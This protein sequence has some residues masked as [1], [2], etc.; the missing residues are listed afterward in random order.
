LI[1]DHDDVDARI[2]KA[3]QF[4]GALRD[5]VFSSRDVPERLKGK[6]FAG[7]FLAVLLYSFESR[8]L[9]AEAIT[10][11]RNWHNKRLREMCRVTM[12]QTFVHR[13]SLR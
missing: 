13:E 5:R 4:F 3:P 1:V 10:R 11:L 8:Y 6:G 9:T 12:C 7:G 2:K